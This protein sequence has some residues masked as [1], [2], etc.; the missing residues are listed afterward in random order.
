MAHLITLLFALIAFAAPAAAAERAA[1]TVAPPVETTK[2]VVSCGAE[3][4]PSTCK[5]LANLLPGGATIIP[6]GA[7]PTLPSGEGGIVL[8]LLGEEDGRLLHLLTLPAPPGTVRAGVIAPPPPSPTF[9]HPGS[10][11]LVGMTAPA[12]AAKT[13]VACVGKG[14]VDQPIPTNVADLFLCLAYYQVEEEGEPLR[15]YGSSDDEER[16]TSLSFP[17]PAVEEVAVPGSPPPAV[18]TKKA[19]VPKVTLV[20]TGGALA[21]VGG[22]Q[23]YRGYTE[24][25]DLAKGINGGEYGVEGDPSLVEPIERYNALGKRQPWWYAMGGVGLGAIGVGIALPSGNNTESP[26][27][28]MYL[29]PTGVEVRGSF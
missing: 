4:G 21:V 1:P 26:P 20:M 28:T 12:I 10:F 23:A 29:S 7:S 19:N 16:A 17:P 2:F 9:A 5:F 8:I 24:A 14:L 13:V 6:P 3:A 22:V 15:T 27:A 11:P 25:R 18:T